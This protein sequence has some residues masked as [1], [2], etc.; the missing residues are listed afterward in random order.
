MSWFDS[1]IDPILANI[2]G[3]TA[4]QALLTGTLF[5][6]TILVVILLAARLPLDLAIIIISPAVILASF[7]GFLPPIAFGVMVLLIAIWFSAI[8]LALA[9]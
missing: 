6:I 5:V 7:A 9:R 8:I 2:I 4:A 3:G 1:L